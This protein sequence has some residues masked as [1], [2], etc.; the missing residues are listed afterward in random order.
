[1]FDWGLELHRPDVLAARVHHPEGVLRCALL[2]Q[3]LVVGVD[4]SVDEDLFIIPQLGPELD[5]HTGHDPAGGAAVK[6][7]HV[8]VPGPLLLVEGAVP[9]EGVVSRAGGE[10]PLP[11][12]R[13]GVG[14]ARGAAARIGVDGVLAPVAEVNILPK[15]PI[16]GSPRS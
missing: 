1:M 16:R 8:V 10:V 2:D 9:V 4:H 13:G 12:V 7:D 11:E 6:L 14:E 15:M 3:V 5:R